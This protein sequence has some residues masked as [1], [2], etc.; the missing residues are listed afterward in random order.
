MRIR[1][2]SDF[3]R[4]D[5]TMFRHPVLL[6]PLR[7]GGPQM[8]DLSRRTLREPVLLDGVTVAASDFEQ[9]K[10][11]LGQWGG[12]HLAGV[13]T[14]MREVVLVIQDPVRARQVSGERRHDFK[15][16][17]RPLRWS[18]LIIVL[19]PFFQGL[20]QGGIF[21]RPAGSFPGSCS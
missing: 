1:T 6:P 4:Y 5:L 20:Y 3:A 2:G 15:R 13:E 18:A 17:L 9:A 11:A 7:F 14:A 19:L 10:A 16:A 8:L 12:V 21:G